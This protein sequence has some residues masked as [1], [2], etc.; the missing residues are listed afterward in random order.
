M[1]ERPQLSFKAQ[2][3][4]LAQAAAQ[5]PQDNGFGQAIQSAQSLLSE[6]TRRSVASQVP[7][8]NG[9]TA[10]ALA[11]LWND[12]NAGIQSAIDNVNG[13]VGAT[14]PSN[15]IANY[16]GDRAKQVFNEL[17]NAGFDG[18]TA[19]AFV[20]NMKDESGLNASITEG[21]PNVHGTRGQGLFQLTDIKPGVGRRT[22]Y[23]NWMKQNNRDDLWSDNSQA[24]FAFWE[25]QNTEKN[26]W[27]KV[28]GMKGVGNK[29]QGI[30]EHVLRPARKHMLER[31]QRYAQL[32][33]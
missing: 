24:N 17:V 22:D 28:Y 32:G 23:L 5:V 9:V 12:R 2:R 13:Q 10:E 19:E 4:A 1:L 33:Y 18:E 27:A 16:G 14:A 3:E 11:A 21:V 25:S 20:I 29:A 31:Q 26:N 30:V 6:A 15:N 8:G 7:A